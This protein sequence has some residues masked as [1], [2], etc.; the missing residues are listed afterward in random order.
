MILLLVALYVPESVQSAL[1]LQMTPV[2]SPV[3]SKVYVPSSVNVRVMESSESNR[4]T[5]TLPSVPANIVLF[6]VPMS[7]SWGLVGP[8]SSPH[9]AM[10]AEI[11]GR[12]RAPR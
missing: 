11:P 8:P 12:Q 2:V 5:M 9:P 1:P 7:L 3:Y 6:Q 4:S 10:R